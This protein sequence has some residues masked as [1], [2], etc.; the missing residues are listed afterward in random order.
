MLKYLPEGTKLVGLY[1]YGGISPY[2]TGSCDFHNQTM[3]LCN[4]QVFSDTKIGFSAAVFR[5]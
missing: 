3:M 2:S 5:S 1:G 4:G